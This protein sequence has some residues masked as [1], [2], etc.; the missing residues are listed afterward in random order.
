MLYIKE[1]DI[2][3]GEPVYDN[4][5]RTIYQDIVVDGNVIGSIMHLQGGQF[6]EISLT[7][8]FGCHAESIP[9][10]SHYSSTE[11]EGWYF[12]EADTLASFIRLYNES[13]RLMFE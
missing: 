2:S 3:Y 7:W 1:E 11:D 12:V 5:G 8:M 13:R 4:G 6:E 9:T 10:G